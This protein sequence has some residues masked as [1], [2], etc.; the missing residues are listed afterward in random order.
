MSKATKRIGRNSP[1]PIQDLDATILRPGCFTVSAIDRFL[2]AVGDRRYAVG[3]NA[4]HAHRALHGLRAAL[5]ESEVVLA[6]AAL[7]AVAFEMHFDVRVGRQVA[8]VRFDD[9]AVLV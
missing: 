8:R 7:V 4:E 5:A 1:S 9:L 6:R 3:G 2:F